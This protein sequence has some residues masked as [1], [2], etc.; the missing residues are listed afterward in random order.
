MIYRIK[1][2][3]VEELKRVMEVLFDAGYFLSDEYRINPG[4]AKGTVDY[5]ILTN[6]GVNCVLYGQSECKRVFNIGF[7]GDYYCKDGTIEELLQLNEI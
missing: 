5:T 7:T 6:E 2:S 4:I 3:D 1:T